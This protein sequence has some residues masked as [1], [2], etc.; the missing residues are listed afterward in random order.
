MNGFRVDNGDWLF[1]DTWAAGIAWEV[2]ST[3]EDCDGYVSV[4]IWDNG[5][6]SYA[7]VM[8]NKESL[9]PATPAEI[10]EAK[11]E[12]TA[13]PEVEVL[14]EWQDEM[15]NY[16]RLIRRN[17][18]LVE[19]YRND[20]RLDWKLYCFQSGAKHIY[21][22]GVAEGKKSCEFPLWI[23]TVDGC[24]FKI[25]TLHH[26]QDDGVS[27]Y[28]KFSTHVNRIAAFG[29]TREEVEEGA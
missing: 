16:C 8:L 18:C 29:N 5:G 12:A 4:R 22:A 20:K 9:R 17:E 7:N 21:A 27:G 24:I 3:E 19:E 2:V 25:E 6:F 23:R 1:N 14:A 15:G 28:F 10:A 13:E 26:S 11:G